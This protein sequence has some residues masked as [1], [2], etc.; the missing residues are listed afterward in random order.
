[1]GSKCK[2][3]QIN[4]CEIFRV[5]RFDGVELNSYKAQ[6]HDWWTIHAIVH[7]ANPKAVIA[8]SYGANEQA[9]VCKWVDDYTGGDT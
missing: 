3:F 5:D 6:A 1:L 4:G 9:S 2:L 7:A 8:F